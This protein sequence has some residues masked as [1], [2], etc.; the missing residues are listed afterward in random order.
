MSDAEIAQFVQENRSSLSNIYALDGYGFVLASEGHFAEAILVHRI[1]ALCFSTDTLVFNSLGDAYR[2][3]GQKR[4][5]RV[6]YQ[7]ALALNP[8]LEN[9][10]QWL[11]IKPLAGITPRL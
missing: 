11:G 6:S 4:L 10:R 2:L 8:N 1:N 7:K 5:A 3:A 9:A